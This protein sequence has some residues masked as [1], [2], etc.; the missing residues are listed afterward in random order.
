MKAC[1]R[2]DVSDGGRCLPNGG[3]ERMKFF[4]GMKETETKDK[5][6]K[7]ETEDATDFYD[8]WDNLEF[9]IM[10]KDGKTAPSN[11]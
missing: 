3:M 9:E 2:P 5:K 4:Y 8:W 11:K 10:P 1:L 7:K 6:K